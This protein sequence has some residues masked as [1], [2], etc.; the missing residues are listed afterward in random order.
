MK[1]SFVL[2]M[3]MLVGLAASGFTQAAHAQGLKDK[4]LGGWRLVEGS[5]L[6]AD[7][8]KVVPWGSGSLIVTRSGHVSFFVLGKDRTPT[9]SVRTPAAPM[10]AWYG[11]YTVDEAANTFTVKVEGASSPAFQGVTRVQTVTFQGDTMTTTGTKVDTPEGPITPVN[12]WK[13]PN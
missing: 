1:K 4:I 8:K 5:E 13:K 9:G 12:V 11:T 2:G 6:F 3:G 10:V 7:G